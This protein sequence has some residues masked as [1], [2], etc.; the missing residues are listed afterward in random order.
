MPRS[1]PGP[2]RS[3]LASGSGRVCRLL[4][5]L[6]NPPISDQRYPDPSRN[7]ASRHHHITTNPRRS[8][9]S[10]LQ[11]PIFSTHNG[12]D[13]A[14]QREHCE[15]TVGDSFSQSMPTR[16]SVHTAVDRREALDRMRAQ[17]RP[18][19]HRPRH[20][21][22]KT[23]TERPKRYPRWTIWHANLDSKVPRIESLRWHSTFA[24][25]TAVVRTTI[26]ENAVCA[27]KRTEAG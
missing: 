16:L 5:Q 26:G 20:D 24:F 17:P 6:E 2:E 1:C 15:L 10:I 4:Q 21:L 14:E 3:A 12:Q 11:N 8:S 9:P 27:D 19:K 7:R 23:P 22:F 13:Q 18:A 25:I